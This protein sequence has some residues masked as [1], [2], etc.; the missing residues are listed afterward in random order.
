M[1]HHQ[2][3][4]PFRSGMDSLDDPPFRE[5]GEALG[6]RLPCEEVS[7]VWCRPSPHIAIGKMTHDFNRNAVLLVDRLRTAPCKYFS[8]HK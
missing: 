3:T 4:R 6:I 2:S 8:I 7:Q 1:A 5:D